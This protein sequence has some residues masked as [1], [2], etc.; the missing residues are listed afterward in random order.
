[1][2]K[3]IKEVETKM[4]GVSQE[5]RDFVMENGMAFAGKDGFYYHYGDVCKL[6]QKYMEK[7]RSGL[8]LLN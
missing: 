7:S 5:I 3:K 8:I 6:I 4:E 1:M 2:A